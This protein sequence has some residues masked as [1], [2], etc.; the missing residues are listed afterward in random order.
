MDPKVWGPHAWLFI[1]SVALQYPDKPTANEK[2]KFGDFFNSLKY[3]LPC[4]KCRLHYTQH[5]KKSPPDLRDKKSLVQWSVDLHNN[6]NASNNKPEID[7]KDFLQFYHKLYNKR[8][9]I[10]IPKIK[11]NKERK[12]IYR[13][14]DLLN[15]KGW[16]KHPW[17]VRLEDRLFKICNVF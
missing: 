16:R 15:E 5:Y 17:L 11:S 14:A 4:R 13:K 1:H 10:S 2:I 3:V 8:I 9:R 6:V 12:I 7:M